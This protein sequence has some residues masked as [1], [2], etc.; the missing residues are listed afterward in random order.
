MSG[1]ENSSLSWQVLGPGDPWLHEYY[2][3]YRPAVFAEESRP[4]KLLV[5]LGSADISGG[6][7]VIFQHAHYWQRHGADVTIATLMPRASLLSHWHPA[8]DELTITTIDDL[9]DEVYDVTVATWWRTVYELPEI[10]TRHALYFVQ[11]IESRFYVDGD[12]TYA[13][14]LAELT[15]RYD[16]PVVTIAQWIQAYLAFE[17]GRPSFLVRNGID[18]NRYSP[19]GPTVEPRRPGRLRVLIEGVT[20][21]AMKNIP[22]SIELARAGGADE[23]WLMTPSDVRRYP[24]VDR[25]LS[26]VD[27]DR[28]GAVYRSCD[29]LV[30]LSRVEGMYGPPLEMFHCGG[31]VV[32]YDV[33]GHEE[34]VVNDVNGLVVPMEQTQGVVA[35]IRKL[36]EDPDALQRLKQGALMTAEH[37]PDWESGCAEFWSIIRLV[38]RR[39][40][41]DKLLSMLA[42]RGAGITGNR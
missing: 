37:W 20:E 7:Y 17:H 12:D 21:V 11:S 28:T 40:A 16:L 36:K 27:I 22:A 5:L 32:T 4:L 42:I 23:V 39:P 26:R 24:G 33:T 3:Q 41:P 19:F 35:S 31:T 18:K 14:P 38:A 10:R 15:Y 29:V 13:A 2:K 9:G 25:V 8:L 34:Y 6:S 30:K 1:V